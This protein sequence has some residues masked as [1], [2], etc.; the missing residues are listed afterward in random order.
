MPP[1]AMA[2]RGNAELKERRPASLVTPAYEDAGLF[3]TDLCR[4]QF[5]LMPATHR[6][7]RKD[8]IVT[9]YAAGRHKVGVIF[10]GRRLPEAASLLQTLSGMSGRTTPG[11]LRRLT[12]EVEGAWRRVVQEDRSG[13]ARRRYDFVAACW[14]LPT[15]SGWSELYGQRP[16]LST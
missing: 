10:A 2:P 12:V 14:K 11:S 7:S 4:V 6:N 5:D 16:V 3:K 13:F 15:P 1:I 9:G 8:V